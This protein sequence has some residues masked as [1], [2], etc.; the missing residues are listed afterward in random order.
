[1]LGE[2][3]AYV[4]SWAESAGLVIFLIMVAITPLVCAFL[5][6]RWAFKRLRGEPAKLLA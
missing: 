6:A 4:A 5:L 2:A 1:M 3:L